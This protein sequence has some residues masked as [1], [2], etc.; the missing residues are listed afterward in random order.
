[1]TTPSDHCKASRSEVQ[2]EDKAWA[3]Q[4]VVD[5]ISIVIAVFVKTVE[6]PGFF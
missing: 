5:L 1:M 4:V 2:V 6:S 3:D